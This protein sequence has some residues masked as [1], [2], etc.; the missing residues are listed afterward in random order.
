MWATTV[1]LIKEK[2][3]IKFWDVMSPLKKIKIVMPKRIPS[4]YS[5]PTILIVS[6]S[7]S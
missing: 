2:I 3:S 4:M 5:D 1:E 7:Y 6:I